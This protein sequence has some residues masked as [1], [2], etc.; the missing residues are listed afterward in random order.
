MGQ[1]RTGGPLVPPAPQAVSQVSA[2]AYLDPLLPV[3]R[4][5][6]VCREPPHP[7]FPVAHVVLPLAF[8]YV[9]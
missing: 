5:L 9:S 3:A 1:T 6:L 8:V 2:G 7:A 4:V